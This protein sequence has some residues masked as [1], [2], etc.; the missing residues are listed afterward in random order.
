MRSFTILI[1]LLSL[2]LLPAAC[3]KAPENG[4][5]DGQ[6]RLTEIH[7]KTLPTAPGYNQVTVKR[8]AHVYWNVQLRLIQFTS[9]EP[10]NPFNGS[11]FARF[12]YVGDRLSLDQLYISTHGRDSLV[13]DPASKAFESIGIRGNATTYRIARLTSTQLI[14][15]SDL[16]S[17]VLRKLH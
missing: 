7:T 12:T 14:L 2:L 4:A 13:T 3:D 11:A 17:L 8:N 9:D 16:D 1:A 10:D 5:L 6:W 15:C